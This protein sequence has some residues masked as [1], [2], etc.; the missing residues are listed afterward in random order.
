M[1]LRGQLARYKAFSRSVQAMALAVFKAL[2]AYNGST[3]NE[4][5]KECKVAIAR[6]DVGPADAHSE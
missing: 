5:R 6:V 2:I 3:A 4:M 1:W